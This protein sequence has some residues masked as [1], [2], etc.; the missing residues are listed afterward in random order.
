MKAVV[1]SF[2]WETE[3]KLHTL[4]V[5]EDALDNARGWADK[6]SFLWNDF[7]PEEGWVH[8]S[9]ADEEAR[10]KFGENFVKSLNG[11]L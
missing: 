2:N 8:F 1:I 10:K 9:Y 3:E 5:G 7:P 4:F 11:G 6:G